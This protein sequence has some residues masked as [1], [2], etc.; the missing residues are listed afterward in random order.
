M[1]VYRYFKRDKSVV[2]KNVQQ[3]VL[4]LGTISF[5]GSLVFDDA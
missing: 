4:S 2:V 1:A 3:S 5:V